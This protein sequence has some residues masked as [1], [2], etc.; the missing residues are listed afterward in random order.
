LVVGSP[1][2]LQL[3]VPPVLASRKAVGWLLALVPTA[4]MAH[5][6]IDQQVTSPSWLRVA[7]EA[8]AGTDALVHVSAVAAEAM[9]PERMAGALAVAP[10]RTQTPEEGQAI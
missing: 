4:V 3:V 8:T 10:I 9:P 2:E 7:P 1:I 5:D 6:V